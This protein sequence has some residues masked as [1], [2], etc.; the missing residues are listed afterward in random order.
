MLRHHT[1]LKQG[2]W[3]EWRIPSFLPST[4][5]TTWV[6]V[7][8]ILSQNLWVNTQYWHQSLHPPVAGR[9]PV[10]RDA[11]RQRVPPR[12]RKKSEQICRLLIYWII[13]QTQLNLSCVWRIIQYITCQCI[14]NGM[15]SIKFTGFYRD[16]ISHYFAQ[17]G[18]QIS[19]SRQHTEV[20]KTF[21]VP[22][23]RTL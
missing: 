14:N 22:R 7:Q 15:S 18:R 12:K 19:T 20:V 10:T 11:E 17:C 8:N 21:L 23:R 2:Q 5:I 16:R 4:L 13:R 1:K 6:K 3:R 9:N